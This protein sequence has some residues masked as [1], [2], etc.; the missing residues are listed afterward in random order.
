M[1]RRTWTLASCCRGAW[2]A[3]V[4]SKLS[5]RF[6]CDSSRCGK[7]LRAS[8]RIT[9]LRE[10]HHHLV[11]SDKMAIQRS[12]EGLQAAGYNTESRL[13]KFCSFEPVRRKSYGVLW[14]MASEPTSALTDSTFNDAEVLLQ[15]IAYGLF[16]GPST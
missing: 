7:P 15:C 3:S 4:L 9:R 2:Q 16:I 14:C 10:L 5:L 6:R 11:P 1:P 8:R 13:H 12:T